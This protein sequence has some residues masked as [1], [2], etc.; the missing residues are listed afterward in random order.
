MTVLRPALA[1]CSF[2]HTDL[3]NTIAIE[4][5]EHYYLSND[6]DLMFVNRAFK[7]E[8]NWCKVIFTIVDGDWSFPIYQHP[9]HSLP[10][11]PI[12]FLILLELK[13]WAA[14]PRRELKYGLSKPPNARAVARLLKLKP[15]RGDTEFTSFGEWDL[16]QFEIVVKRYSLAARGVFNRW[17]LHFTNIF[18]SADL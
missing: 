3:A 5:P 14:L 12:S 15:Q 6:E 1:D 7:I 10:L 18:Q 16:E 13:N 17:E 11:P 8:E 9:S 2:D 4:D